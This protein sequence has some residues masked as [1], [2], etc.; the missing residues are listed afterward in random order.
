LSRG[1][2]VLNVAAAS[3][4]PVTLTGI[5]ESTDRPKSTLVRLLDVL[6]GEGYVMQVDERPASRLGH[7]LLPWAVGYFDTFAGTELLR[8]HLAALAAD[9]GWTANFGTLD[10]GRV[11]HLC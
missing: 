4:D 1:L 8:P 3:A 6:E 5:H 10:G 7:A 11:I 2:E 9:T